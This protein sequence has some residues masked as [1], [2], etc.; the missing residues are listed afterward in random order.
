MTI[1]DNT[2]IAAAEDD[3]AEGYNFEGAGAASSWSDFA[4]AVTERDPDA[5]QIAFTGAGAALDSLGTI[6]NPFDALLESALGFAIEHVWFLHE[7]LDALA[8]DPKQILAQATTWRNVSRAL[9]GVSTEYTAVTP[10]EPGWGG[11]AGNGYRGAVG[12]YTG[13]L[14]Q[15]SGHAEQLSGLILGS[16]AAVGTV[17][18]LIRDLIAEFIRWLIQRGIAALMAASV[19]AGGA[20]GLFIVGVVAEAIA[21]AQDIARRISR[22]LDLL[23]ATG[24][25]AGQIVDGM[26]YAADEVRALAPY[27]QATAKPLDDALGEVPGSEVIEA[28]KQFT[29]AKLDDDAMRPTPKR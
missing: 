14:D 7:P 25:T 20:I 28:G 27:M 12:G 5:A 15:V 21:L 26:R 19:T 10:A 8:G 18:A 3:R 1:S 11:D 24:G 17:R 16:G 2:L 29:G 22:L 23:A 6:A 13:A 4:T 9:A